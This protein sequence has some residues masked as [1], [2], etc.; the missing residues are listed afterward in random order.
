MANW[1]EQA[2]NDFFQILVSVLVA[3]VLLVVINVLS[4][5]MAYDL[6]YTA[7]YVKYRYGEPEKQGQ[8]L[9]A[10]KR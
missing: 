4:M 9:L 3:V 6:G 1:E 7:G 2:V 10:E 5:S 8:Q